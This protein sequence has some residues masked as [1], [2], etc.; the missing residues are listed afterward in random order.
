M[1][2]ESELRRRIAALISGDESLDDFED[3]FT[4][5]SWNA[6]QDS[7]PE[8][9]R[10]VGWVELRL[11]EYSSGHLSITELLSEMEALVITVTCQT[12]QRTQRIEDDPE[13]VGA[14]YPYG[15]QFVECP[16]GGKMTPKRNT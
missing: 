10:L 6:H 8:A 3:W 16:C 1:I 5:A 4:L 15:W 14:G 9:R 12:C 11:A 2:S 7:S 13:H